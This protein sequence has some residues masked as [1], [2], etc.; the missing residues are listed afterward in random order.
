MITLFSLLYHPFTHQESAWE[1]ERW[2]KRERE[3][4]RVHTGV[5]ICS[6]DYGWM[7]HV[8]IWLA[9][10]K[11]YK[12]GVLTQAITCQ[13]K[14][15]SGAAELQ[16][17]CCRGNTGDARDPADF[18]WSWKTPGGSKSGLSEEDERERKS[19][20]ASAFEF[21]AVVEKFFRWRF[22][23]SKSLHWPQWEDPTVCANFLK[24]NLRANWVSRDW[25]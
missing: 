13:P 18:G 17:P 7:T 6:W 2:R 23:V 9:Y 14:F 4:C 3:K 25:G 15:F 12:H 16:K 10:Y 11:N 20:F 5:K 19:A 8:S 1:R 22:W 21:I 24:A